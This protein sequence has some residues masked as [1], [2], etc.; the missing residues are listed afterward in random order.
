MENHNYL[1]VDIETI[2][3]QA[4]RVR[5]HFAAKIKTPA[6]VEKAARLV[7]GEEVPQAPKSLK[8]PESIDKWYA[9]E[10][11]K[12][13]DAAASTV[14]HWQEAGIDEATDEMLAKTSLTG[15]WGE[16]AAIGW[17]INAGE[18]QTAHRTKRKSS[19]AMVLEEFFAHVNARRSHRGITI[20][21]HNVIGFDIRFIMQRAIL[22][23]VKLPSWWPQDPKPWSR[24]VFDTMARWSGQRDWVKLDD[25]CFAMGIKV[26]DKWGGALPGRLDMLLFY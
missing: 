19:E 16:I 13:I 1:F 5:K 17:A 22:N 10:A 3:A 11:P 21:G 25:L 24:E 26:R 4:R 12:V 14:A 2:P 9:E 18:I 20:V 23:E 6:E 15:T 7:A 8:K